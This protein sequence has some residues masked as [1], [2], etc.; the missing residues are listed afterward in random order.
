[1][2][3]QKQLE[4]RKVA[5]EILDRIDWLSGEQAKAVD[6]MDDERLM[7]LDKQLEIEFGAKQRA[8]GALFE[9]RNEH[10]C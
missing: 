1:M 4:L 3:C 5:H 7:A 8:F 2:E 6:N 9:H 10:G